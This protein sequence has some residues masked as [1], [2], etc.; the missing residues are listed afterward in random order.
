MCQISPRTKTK[1]YDTKDMYKDGRFVTHMYMKCVSTVGVIYTQQ[2]NN[3][4][5]CSYVNLYVYETLSL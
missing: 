5:A 4:P 2:R 1:S 3:K